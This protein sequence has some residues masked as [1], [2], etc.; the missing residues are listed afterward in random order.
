MLERHDRRAA[1]LMREM[2]EKGSLVE[3]DFYYKEEKRKEL[4]KIIINQFSAKHAWGWN[5]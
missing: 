4:E 1:E 2:Q 5:D 3:Q